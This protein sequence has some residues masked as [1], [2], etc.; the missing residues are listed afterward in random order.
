LELVTPTTLVVGI[1]G[2]A[3]SNTAAFY[4]A[5]G[6]EAIRPK[7]FRNDRKGFLGLIERVD[8]LKRRNGL[9]RVIYVLE[10]N[11]PYWMLLAKFLTERREIVKVVSALQVRR[12]REMRTVRRRRTTTETRGPQPTWV[13]RGS[14]TTR[15]FHPGYTKT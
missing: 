10:P 5:T 8:G 4:L 13:G 12:N 1:D 15:F 3:Q 2:H 9:D 14:S 7:K 11:G 6:V